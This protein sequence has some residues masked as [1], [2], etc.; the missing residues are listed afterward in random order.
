MRLSRGSGFAPPPPRPQAELPRRNAPRHRA[1]PAVEPGSC[2][3]LLRARSRPG[4]LGGDDQDLADCLCRRCRRQEGLPQADLSNSYRVPTR[5][6]H[7]P[8]QVLFAVKCADHYRLPP[9]AAAPVPLCAPPTTSP[10]LHE[11]IW[12]L[13]CRVMPEMCAREANAGKLD[14]HLWFF[15]AFAEALQPEYTFLLDVGTQPGRHSLLKLRDTLRTDPKVAGC[16]GQIEIGAHVI[17]VL[18]HSQSRSVSPSVDIT[19]WM[20][21]P[22][23]SRWLTRCHELTEI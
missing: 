14:S 23:E 10:I 5:E 15:D 21:I 7:Q 13:T 3:A 11:S 17:R 6:Y 22:A 20:P 19:H 2:G 16:C 4:C 18:C 12:G 8:L 1:G 9:P